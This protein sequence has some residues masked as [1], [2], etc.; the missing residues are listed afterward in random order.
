MSLTRLKTILLVL[1]A[2]ALGM[3]PALAQEQKKEPDKNVQEQKEKPVALNTA[4]VEALV[5]YTIIAVD[6]ANL[7]GNYEVL[8][9][10][11][12][13][14][15]QQTT[16][17]DMLAKSFAKMRETKLALSPVLLVKPVFRKP[18]VLAKGVLQV[19]GVFPTKPTRIAFEATY[20]SVEGRMRLAG[21]KITPMKNEAATGTNSGKKVDKKGDKQP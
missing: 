19:T 3:A 11:G 2:L 4:F 21:L 16:T 17:A 13:P 12:T 6:Q 8:R 15:F 18:P 7:T 10:L 20:M 1:A 14:K 9:G 5:K